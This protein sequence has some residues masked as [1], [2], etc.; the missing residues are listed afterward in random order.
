MFFSESE[1]LSECER[2]PDCK[3]SRAEDRPPDDRH[4]R[5]EALPLS[6][7]IDT[8]S[9]MRSHQ[10]T[11]ATGQI[12]ELSSPSG[13]GAEAAGDN[14]NEEL[15]D[16]AVGG[17][18]EAAGEN[19]DFASLSRSCVT[20]FPSQENNAGRTSSE[21]SCKEDSCLAGGHI[22]ASSYQDL[23][24]TGQFQVSASQVPFGSGFG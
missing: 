8:S 14:D 16:G 17:R 18:Q 24:H 3:Q 4:P 13:A 12:K 6:P 7:V 21:D 23:V 5:A 9:A 20:D 22:A 11:E 2:P 1:E 19:D 15:Q 10:E